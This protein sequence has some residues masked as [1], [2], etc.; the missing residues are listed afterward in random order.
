MFT[1]YTEIIEPL[2]QM[3]WLHYTYINLLHAVIIETHLGNRH[4]GHGCGPSTISN[5]NRFPVTKRWWSLQTP[6]GRTSR[7]PGAQGST[8]A[9]SDHNWWSNGR[10]RGRRPLRRWWSPKLVFQYLLLF[11]DGFRRWF[12]VRPV[13]TPVNRHWC[14]C[15]V[16]KRNKWN[17]Y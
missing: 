11:Q 1:K 14:R 10:G 8:S 5:G 16:H 6:S 4:C 3:A 15:P 9:L 2:F 12:I 17:C 13:I 7:C